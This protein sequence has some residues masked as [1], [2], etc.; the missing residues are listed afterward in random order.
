M[1]LRKLEAFCKVI[2]SGSFTQAGK[3]MLLSQP[4]ISEHIRYLEEEFEEKLLER[5]GREINPTP[6]GAVLYEYASRV[7]QARDETIQAV[8]QFSGRMVGTVTIGC[9]TIPGTYIIPRLLGTFRKEYSSI[10][11]VLRI[12]S[13]QIIA[14]AVVAGKL[15]LGVVG[16][17][18]NDK[19]L[20][21]T[22]IFSDALTV[23]VPPD[24]KWKKR[25]SI[26]IEELMTEP[27]VMRE[28]ESGTRKVI[29]DILL[30]SGY[31]EQNLQKVAEIGSTA[32]VKEAVKAKLGVAIVS[33]RAV[34]DAIGC[35]K[36]CSVGIDGQQLGRPFYL[37]QRKNRA[38]SPVTATFLDFLVAH[39]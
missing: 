15:E 23:I 38:L 19:A 5:H 35:G 22:R 30:K 17:K 26:T 10:N 2:D 32:A 29:A 13:S 28:R 8:K 24:H 27:F 33:K 7:L 9:G 18:W 31:K 21:W 37:V 16:A 20:S 34:V 14:E 1:E 25:K 4:T 39:S 3:E 11:T 36:L 6:V 12:A